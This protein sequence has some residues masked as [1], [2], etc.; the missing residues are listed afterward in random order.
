MKYNVIDIIKSD[1]TDTDLKDIVN[2]KLYKIILFLM[3]ENDYEQ[4]R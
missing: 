1:I 2:K 3:R 4:S